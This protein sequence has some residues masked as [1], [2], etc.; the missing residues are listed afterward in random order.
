MNP[1]TTSLL[2]SSPDEPL[3]ASATEAVDRGLDLQ[4]QGNLEQAA[5]MYCRALSMDPERADAIC[6]LGHLEAQR[7][8]HDDAI[9]L[10]RRAVA[11][12]PE[13]VEAHH[14]LGAVLQNRGQFAEA[15]DRFDHALAIAPDFVDARCGRATAL[16]SLGRSAEAIPQFEQVLSDAPEMAVAELGLAQALEAV[17]REHEAFVHYRNAANLNPWYTEAL[18]QALTAYANRNPAEAQIGVQRL[19]TFIKN[20][21]FNHRDPRMNIYPGLDSQP[22]RDPQ[23]FPVTRALQAAIEPIC[24]EIA[25]LTDAAY[26]PELESDLMTSGAWDSAM[27]Y[28]RGRKNVRNCSLCPTITRIIDAHDTLRTQAGVLYVSKLAPHSHIGAH[29]GPTNIR[30]RCHLGVQIPEGDCAIRVGNE[31]RRWREGECL[32]FDD[33]L[34]HESW[35]HTD[36]PRIVLIVDL[37]HAQLTPAEIVFLE[38]LHRFGAHMADTLASY[39]AK[40]EQSQALARKLYD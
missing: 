40:K 15:L 9:R 32:V 17:S 20:L 19:N 8:R 39:W 16:H 22:F 6:Y 38:G 4:D 23:L 5:L 2:T 33:R 1:T 24:G 35:N 13:L 29:H 10:L 27:L 36:E 11:L 7:G 21:L 28:E 14:H 25:R 12:D 34:E 18:D 30:T 3:P 37:W 31:T 26:A